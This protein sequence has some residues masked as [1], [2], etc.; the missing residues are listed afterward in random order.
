MVALF[1]RHTF[2]HHTHVDFSDGLVTRLGVCCLDQGVH[3]TTM[4]REL[5]RA[6]WPVLW[7][8]EDEV[9]VEDTIFVLVEVVQNSVPFLVE[10]LLVWCVQN[11]LD[12]VKEA[13][14]P[15]TTFFWIDGLGLVHG[16]GVVI[17]VQFDFKHGSESFR[18]LV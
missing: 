14:L 11:G 12:C 10:R 18:F 3:D 7:E 13:V 9:L 4:H 6:T 16:F 1:F 8:T 15:T 2:C 17:Q 5:L